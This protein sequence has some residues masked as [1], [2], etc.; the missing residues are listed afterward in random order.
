MQQAT[1]FRAFSFNWQCDDGHDLRVGKPRKR[2]TD[3]PVRGAN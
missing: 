2:K 3:V 1:S